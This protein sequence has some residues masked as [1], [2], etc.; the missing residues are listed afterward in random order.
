MK[1]PANQRSRE[2]TDAIIH[3]VMLSL[4]CVI[5]CWLITHTLAR[6]FAVSRDEELLGG[7]WA[8]VATIFVIATGTTKLLRLPY[9]AWRQPCYVLC[10]V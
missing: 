4:L 2:A 8:V 1:T 5:S 10:S 7:M 6:A 9:R 3:G